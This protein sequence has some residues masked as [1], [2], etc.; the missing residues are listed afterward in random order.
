[1]SKLRL[2][3]IDEANRGA[4]ATGAAPQAPSAVLCGLPADEDP[5]GSVQSGSKMSAV[6]LSP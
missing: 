1:M 3:V 4:P 6:A 5:D 2:E